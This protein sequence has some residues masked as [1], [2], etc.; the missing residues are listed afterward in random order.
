[1][2]KSFIA[3]MTWEEFRDSVDSTTV[4]IIPMGS[5]ELE[6]SHLPL[7]VDTIVVNGIAARLAGEPGTLIGPALPIGYS[8]WFNPSPGTISL[9][10]ETLSMVLLDYCE[11]LIRHG[12]E[13]LVFLN[14]HRGNNSA[15]ETTAHRLIASR[16]VRLGTLSIWKL[17]NDLVSGSDLIVEGKFTHA[18]EIM[19]S[20]I[21]AL[22]PDTVVFDKIRPDHVKSPAGTDFAVKNS[23]GETTFKGSVQLIFQDIHELTDTGIMGDP[24]AAS[25]AKGEKLLDLVTGYL[26]DF[27]QEFRKIP[28]HPTGRPYDPD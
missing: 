15:I 25:K 20:I 2:N 23:L 13:R 26:K 9:E 11:C 17:A 19:T 10:H 24:T 3:D 8:K 14:C 4:V 5:I 21:M 6:G 7:G 12:V 1:M 22:R 27:I 16:P 28:L 18:G